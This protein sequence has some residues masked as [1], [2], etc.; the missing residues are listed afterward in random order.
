MNRAKILRA[1]IDR[2]DNAII[3]MIKSKPL[4]DV[5]RRQK[6]RIES[7]E[8][9]KRREA[10]ATIRE[11]KNATEVRHKIKAVLDD[12]NRRLKNPTE[13]SYI[14]ANMVQL[15]IAAEEL[16]DTRSGREGEK[17][18]AKLAALQGMYE[19]YKSDATFAY[20]YDPVIA[21]M[22]GSLSNVVGNKNIYQ[23]NSAE[24]QSVYE[25]LKALKKQVTE[26]VQL[27]AGNYARTIIEAGREMI[28]ETQAAAPP[29]KGKAGEFLN[30]QLTPD[31]FF[32]R[33]AGFK[34]NS[35]WSK[36]AESFSKGTEKMLEIQRDH[37]YHF[38][39]FTESKEFDKLNDQKHL[40]D[41]GLTND[42]GET[43]K[44]TR[45]M[46]LSA[47]MHLSNE[48]NARG[49]MYGGFSI[50]N[51]KAYYDGKVKESMAMQCEYLP[52]I[53]ALF[54]DVNPIPVK[55]AM[56]MLGFCRADM[57]EPLFPMETGKREALRELLKKA[58]LDPTHA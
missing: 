12:F 28:R 33:L 29:A 10:I 15:V 46:M 48:E 57:R 39:R 27:K 3:E 22:L 25:T 26:A 41:I 43:V 50:P 58:G 52:L 18:Q 4:Q 11:R 7:I 32:A 6:Q 44:V 40:V 54:S 56:A 17:A 21:D 19:R 24:L 31:K 14:P 30:W 45:G 51:L 2:E 8:A 9:G 37:Y 20:V 23:L 35:I 42:K 49:F 47:Y 34:K 38:K 1:Q 55:E 16:I 36:V 13:K 53:N 5:L